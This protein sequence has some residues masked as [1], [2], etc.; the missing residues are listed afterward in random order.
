MIYLSINVD[1][2]GILIEIMKSLTENKNLH[3]LYIFN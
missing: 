2:F 3:P 1:F